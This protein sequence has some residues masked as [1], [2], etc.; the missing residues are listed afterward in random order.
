MAD[1][2]DPTLD[3]GATEMQDAINDLHADINVV[4]AAIAVMADG[5]EKAALQGHAA[6]I[7]AWHLTV[8]TNVGVNI[9][10]RDDRSELLVKL[11]LWADQLLPP[12]ISV[13]DQ[14]SIR[15]DIIDTVTDIEQLIR[16]P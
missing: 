13:A 10:S 4:D 15:T 3:T 5:P 11:H 9:R 16:A 12:R 7:D 6:R 8:E 14:V 1:A 2:F